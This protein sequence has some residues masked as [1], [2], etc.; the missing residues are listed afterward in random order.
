MM[1]ASFATLGLCLAQ[2]VT[3]Q[4][5]QVE[6]MDRT[7]IYRVNVVSRTAKAV[8]YRH[9]SGSTKVDLQ[10][11]A[12]MPRAK[13]D[14]KVESKQGYLE[15][16][17][18]F[19]DMDAP[20]KYGR[21]YM[22]YVLW[23]ITPEGRPKNLGEVILNGTT[24]SKLDVTTE[25]Q[26]FGLIVTA[27]PYFA[28]TMPSDVVVMENIIRHDTVGKIEEIDAKYELLPRGQYTINVSP[29]DRRVKIVEPKGRPS[30]VLQ[31]RNAVQIAQWAGATNT[32]V[33]PIRRPCSFRTKRKIISSG[34]TPRRSRPP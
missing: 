9:R 11:T 3:V 29:D 17:A 25:L 27:E 8:N 30:E 22:T 18:H 23:A 34:S 14:A 21:E 1:S 15:I 19:K 31:A 33:K 24:N 13:G 10:G 16:D 7:P 32:R 26:A 2:V 5:T 28:V 6:R 12:L 20:N 4:N